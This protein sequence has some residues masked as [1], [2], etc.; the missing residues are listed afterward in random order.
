MLAEA[1]TC[2]MFAFALEN[3]IWLH[4]MEGPADGSPI[5]LWY[6]AVHCVV[7]IVSGA[8]GCIA[9]ITIQSWLHSEQCLLQVCLQ[10]ANASHI[11]LWYNAI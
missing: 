8:R 7:A 6:N 3:V 11:E 5:K 10:H 4:L 2:C 1:K 9:T